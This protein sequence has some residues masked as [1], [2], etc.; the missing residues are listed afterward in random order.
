MRQ[1]LIGSGRRND[2]LETKALIVL[3]VISQDV[4]FQNQY[5]FMFLFV[6]SDDGL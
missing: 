4:C 6:C 5:V 2:Y 3:I 1:V